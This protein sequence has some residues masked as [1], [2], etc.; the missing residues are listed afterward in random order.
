VNG[1]AVACSADPTRAS[2]LIHLFAAAAAAAAAG[3][4]GG[5][6]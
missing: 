6:R 5:G 2:L 4:G 3:G 1:L